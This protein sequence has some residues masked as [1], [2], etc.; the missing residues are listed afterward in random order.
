MYITYFYFLTDALAFHKQC[1]IVQ[2]L[3]E[4]SQIKEW[5]WSKVKD[6]PGKIYVSMKSASGNI[7]QKE[8]MIIDG[9]DY[10]DLLTDIRR[11]PQTHVDKDEDS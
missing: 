8:Y 7:K 11:F 6:E 1:K 4:E 10:K 5:Q 3:F 9:T 2:R